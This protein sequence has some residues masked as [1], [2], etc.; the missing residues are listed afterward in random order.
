MPPEL[1]AK[2]RELLKSSTR[3]GD[4]ESL[5]VIA[6]A[7]GY[8]NTAAALRARAAQLRGQVT[9]PS[10]PL[11]DGGP[12]ASPP[13]P[14][15]TI[16]PPPVVP[17]P[18]V[19]QWPTDP[20]T[21]P[22]TLPPVPVQL[23]GVPPIVGPGAPPMPIPIPVSPP[24]VPAVSPLAKTYKVVQGDNPSKIAQRFTGTSEAVRVRELAAANPDK[25][26]R[27]LAGT[28]Y[29]GETLTIPD[30]WPTKPGFPVTVTT[31]APVVVAP[32]AALHSTI[33]KGSTGPDVALW[34][35]LVGVK[36]DGIFGPNTDAATRTWQAPPRVAADGILGPAT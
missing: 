4:L 7:R 27:I 3:P 22:R 35:T 25:S 17:T 18:P 34:Q 21:P 15:P 2:G 14:P 20:A 6:D 26:G 30:A 23:P 31:P 24:G 29:V 36:A 19:F 13:A 32:I 9:V 8:H 1:D 10:V 16:E 5:A 12:G 28:I 33:Q 11:P